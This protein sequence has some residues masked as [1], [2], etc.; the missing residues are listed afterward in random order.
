M[1][2]L[3][4]RNAG[5]IARISKS[6]LKPLFQQHEE[7]IIK[8]LIREYKGGNINHNLMVGSI[9]ALALMHDIS[10]ALQHDIEKGERAAEKDHNK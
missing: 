2:T 7:R 1:S 8:N 4:D 6:H 5:A 10:T 3:D 9:G